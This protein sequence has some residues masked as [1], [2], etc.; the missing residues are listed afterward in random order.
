MVEGGNYLLILFYFFLVGVRQL[1]TW[2]FLESLNPCGQ[3]EVS[4][5][6]FIYLIF[7][8]FL[9]FFFFLGGGGGG[10]WGIWLKS[11]YWRLITV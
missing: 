10:I 3:G 11:I 5:L 1:T 2:A 9:I 6:L 7:L 8:S 4:F